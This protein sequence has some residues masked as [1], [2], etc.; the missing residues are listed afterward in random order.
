M[1]LDEWLPSRPASP[2]DEV[3]A[4]LAARYLATRAPVTPQDFAWWSGLPVPRARAALASAGAPTLAL[5]VPAATALLLPAFDEYALSY[6]DRSAVLAAAHEKAIVPGG[7]GIFLP[8][9]VVDGQIVGT[10]K[11]TQTTK[12]VKLALAPFQPLKPREGRALQAAAAR[13]GAFLEAHVEI[14]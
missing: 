9:I 8:M 1:L 7:N 5:P 12:R 2:E 10:W 13:F 14:A 3:L 4:G 11:R 6:R